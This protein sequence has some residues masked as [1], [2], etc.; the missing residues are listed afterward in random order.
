MRL[1]KPIQ[2]KGKSKK[3]KN[4]IVEKRATLSLKV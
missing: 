4:G 1:D 3:E 2:E